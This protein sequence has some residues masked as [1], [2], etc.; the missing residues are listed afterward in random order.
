[1][2]A[3]EWDRVEPTRTHS[4]FLIPHSPSYPSRPRGRGERP[5]VRPPSRRGWRRG[6]WSACVSKARTP[7]AAVGRASRR[8]WGRRDRSSQ[9]SASATYRHAGSGRAPRAVLSLGGGTYGGWRDR[10]TPRRAVSERRCRASGRRRHVVRSR[11]RWRG[12]RLAVRRH[13]HG[14][15]RRRGPRVLTEKRAPEPSDFPPPAPRR[16]RA[17]SARSTIPR[18][19]AR[20]RTA[21]ETARRRS[22]VRVAEDVLDG[23]AGGARATSARPSRG[24]RARRRRPLESRAV[25]AVDSSGSHSAFGAGCPARAAEASTHRWRSSGV[26]DR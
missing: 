5:A 7:A 26:T 11:R 2:G 8:G 14:D 4:R 20:I 1:M 6:A 15:R 17:A 13:V 23:L 25:R 10:S 19:R 9:S 3:G 16:R 22:K 21:G 18:S 12:R 24:R